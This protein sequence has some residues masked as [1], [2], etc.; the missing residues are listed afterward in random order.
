MCREDAPFVIEGEG[1]GAL[2]IYF[3]SQENS[4]NSS[5]KCIISNHPFVYIA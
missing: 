2:K 3:E 1:E 5:N 4:L